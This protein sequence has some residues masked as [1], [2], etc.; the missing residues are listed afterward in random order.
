MR[1]SG[2]SVGR[3]A[4]HLGR[5]RRLKR[6][7]ALDRHGQVV[8]KEISRAVS[9]IAELRAH[10]QRRSASICAICAADFELILDFVAVQLD[11]F[12]P[13]RARNAVFVLESL[14]GDV[15]G[16]ER[17]RVVAELERD[18][19]IVF[20]PYVEVEILRILRRRI[21]RYLGDVRLASGPLLVDDAPICPGVVGRALRVEA[22]CL[23]EVG[24]LRIVGIKIECKVV[25]TVSVGVFLYARVGL[26]TIGIQ[27]DNV[28][29]ELGRPLWKVSNA[30]V[31]VVQEEVFRVRGRREPGTLA[32]AYRI[33]V[34]VRRKLQGEG[35]IAK[36]RGECAGNLVQLSDTASGF[37]GEGDRARASL[38][39]YNDA[40]LKRARRPCN[41]IR[42]N[43]TRA[44]QKRVGLVEYLPLDA[45]LAFHFIIRRRQEAHLELNGLGGAKRIVHRD[46]RRHRHK[47]V[48][49]AVVCSERR[50]RKRKRER[51]CKVGV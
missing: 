47:I 26:T 49:V 14:L 41:G 12:H 33:A 36:L 11:L 19:R 13:K 21:D 37:L 42:G 51:G 29:R 9:K 18:G 6:L 10:H 22:K 2:D 24:P 25:G 23:Y 38:P 46:D 27:P 8:D 20:R 32:V 15:G 44:R 3:K 28:R 39:A 31:A 35:E 1:D 5:N 45:I 17:R 50:N 34:A 16:R 43:G 4:V 40:E 7:A 30:P 48:D